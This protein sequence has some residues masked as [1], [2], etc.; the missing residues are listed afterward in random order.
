[1]TSPLPSDIELSSTPEKIA[2]RLA[3]LAGSEP[4]LKSIPRR[5]PS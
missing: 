5:R 3:S 4:Q 1:M 2:R